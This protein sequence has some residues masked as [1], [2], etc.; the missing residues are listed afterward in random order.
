[1][2]RKGYYNPLNTFLKRYPQTVAFFF[3]LYQRYPNPLRVLFTVLF[4]LFILPLSAQVDLRK[5]ELEI[6]PNFTNHSIHV[7]CR[8]RLK[9]DPSQPKLTL[10]LYPQF[11]IEAVQINGSDVHHWK[12]NEKGLEIDLPGG[13]SLIDISINYS[14]V[15]VE[16][17]NPPWGNGFIWETDQDGNPWLGVVCEHDGPQIWWPV[18]DNYSDKIDQLSVAA[19][20]PENLFFKGNGQ[21]VYDEKLADGLRKSIWSVTYPINAYNVTLNIGNYTHIQ[22]SL[23]RKDGSSLRLNYYP[24][25]YNREKAIR[26]FEQVKPMLRCFEKA[27]G[28]YP[29]QRDGYSVVETPYVGMEHQGAVAYG[30][31]WTNGYTGSDYSGIDLWFD[32]ILIHETGHEWWGNSVS[33][34]TKTDFWLQEAFCTYAEYVFVACEFG[35]EKAVSYINAKKRL[36][37][38]KVAILKDKSGGIDSYAKGAL[39]LNTLSHFA[40]DE[41]VWNELLLEFAETF[42]YKSIST[43][44]LMNWFSVRLVGATPAFFKQYL[45][46]AEIPKL[47]LRREGTNTL[48]YRISNGI[49]GAKIPIYFTGKTGVFFATSQWQH[50]TFE[51]ESPLPDNTKS[52][53]QFN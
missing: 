1:L 16:A 6:K 21:L 14:G 36:V 28:N 17:K 23:D 2:K 35:K 48:A 44:E 4:A 49:E 41:K 20:Y 29:F 12:R 52:Y 45:E 9:V 11:I 38:N 26:Q 3:D 53:F 34:K 31:G 47:E 19:I 8:E 25:T 51:G 40:K 27:F 43:T 7:V 39:M 22:D 15:P 10:L 33:A 50:F 24:L 37:E 42:R 5:L 30:N 46:G 18:S 13:D 32:F